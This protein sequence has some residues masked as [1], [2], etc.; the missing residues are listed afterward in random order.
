MKQER[1]REETA[2]V[3]LA[4]LAGDDVLA[5]R[6]RG[7]SHLKAIERLAGEARFVVLDF[8]GIRAIT[9]S[10]FL[11]GPMTLWARDRI[12][13]DQYVVVAN[14]VD[15]VVGD[16]EVVSHLMDQPIWV[17]RWGRGGFRSPTLLGKVDGIDAAVIGLLSDRGRITATELVEIRDERIGATG[18]SNRLAGLSQKKILQRWREGRKHVYALPWGDRQNG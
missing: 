2:L 11:A 3:A 17:G 10:Y 16:V 9:A 6:R 15:D 4:D 5:A 12:A 1:V 8:A 7:A 14:V 18:W 13:A